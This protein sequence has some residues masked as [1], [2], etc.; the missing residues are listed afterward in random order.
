MHYDADVYPKI[1]S[2]K[3][4]ARK[5]DTYNELN[6]GTS[7]VSY[8]SQKGFYQF[9]EIKEHSERKVG[10]K[11]CSTFSLNSGIYCSRAF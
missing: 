5:L 1:S 11:S 4:L 7:F 2:L 9:C 10:Y 3:K 6:K 8:F